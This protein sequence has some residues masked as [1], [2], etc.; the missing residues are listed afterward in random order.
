MPD[1]AAGLLASKVPDKDAVLVVALYVCAWL[2]TTAS[3]LPP[4]APAEK[5]PPSPIKTLPAPNAAQVPNPSNV[6]GFVATVAV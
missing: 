6:P 4:V 1:A 5:P 3:A 2:T